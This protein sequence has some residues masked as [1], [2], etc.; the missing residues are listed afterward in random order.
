MYIA[1]ARAFVWVLDKIH[2]SLLALL[3]FAN[4]EESHMVW[5]EHVLV[6]YMYI[7]SCVILSRTCNDLFGVYFEK[8]ADWSVSRFL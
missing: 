3:G 1:I 4:L 5:I 8:I 7:T 6:M 2:Q